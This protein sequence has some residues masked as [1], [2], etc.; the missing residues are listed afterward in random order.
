MRRI[1]VILSALTLTGCAHNSPEQANQALIAAD[2]QC[3]A[4]KWDDAASHQMC[5]N[6]VEEPIIR[7]RL[8]AALDS[9]RRFSEQ[10]LD[11]AR[12]TDIINAPVRVAYEKYQAGYTEVLTE[13]RAH[14]P[15]RS[16]TGSV[17]HKEI[18]SSNYE[19]VCRAGHSSAVDQIN[20]MYA[21][22]RPI[23]ERDAPE[24]VSSFDNFENKY[25]ALGREFDAEMAKPEVTKATKRAQEYW[26]SG[27]TRALAEWRANVARDIQAANERD[28]AEST[29]RAETL[30]NIFKALALGVAAGAEA[31]ANADAAI[32]NSIQQN[33]IPRPVQTSCQWVGTG[34]S[35]QWVCNTY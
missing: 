29:Q 30:S 34:F 25:L 16:D 26:V 23:W 32:S 4:R 19:S 21:I 31:R 11:L 12:Q 6:Q 18:G 20:C 27:I 22:I 35:R 28:A 14:E 10:R 5:L 13:L 9:F 24:S 17:L 7:Q 33:P 2:R 3:D 1:A 15:K 8:P